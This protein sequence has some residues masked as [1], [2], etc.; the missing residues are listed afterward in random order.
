M[1]RLRGEPTS[2]DEL[3]GEVVEIDGQRGVLRWQML[4][5]KLGS[6]GLLEHSVEHGGRVVAT[7]RAIGS[8]AASAGGKP[9]PNS[10][11]KLSRFATTRACEG[12]LLVETP[13]SHLGVELA[14]EIAPLLGELALDHFV[15][16]LTERVALSDELVTAVLGMFQSADLLT[17][18]DREDPET[19]DRDLAQWSSVDLWQHR[20]SRGA[21]PTGRYGGTYPLEDRFDPLPALPPSSGTRRVQL[22]P[23]DSVSDV[24]A[25]TLTGALDRRRSVRSHDDESPLTL[26]QLGGLLYRSART[27]S[28]FAMDGDEGSERPYPSGGALHELELYPIISSCTDIEPGFWHYASAEHALEFVNEPNDA[29]RALVEQA[30][31]ASMM[32]SSPQVVLVIAARFGRVLWKYEGMGYALMLKHVGVLYQTLY[33]VATAMGLAGCALGGG[34]ADTF[35]RATGISPLAQGSVGEFVVGSLPG[36]RR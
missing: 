25:V 11:I 27:K 34:N 15:T 17:S 35:A 13:L 18:F 28:T 36:G 3:A 1:H 32:E 33:L 22:K 4:L 12:V 19:A 29:T 8:G 30:R 21:G 6:S 5:R 31:A 26:D 14:P 24:D 7:L 23:V 16:E 20:R 9:D 2:E 10:R